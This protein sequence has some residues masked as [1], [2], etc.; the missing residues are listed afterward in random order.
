MDMMNCISITKPCKFGPDRKME[1][2][3]LVEIIQRPVPTLTPGHA[4]IRTLYGGVC[5]SDIGTYL[6]SFLYAKYPQIPGHEFAGEIV[7]IDENNEYGLKKGMIVTI[8]P[9]Y[10][11]GKCYTCRHGFVNCCPDNQTM[12]CSSRDGAFCQYISM[13][14]ERIYDGKGMKARTLALIEPFCIS[15]HAVKRANIQPG[16]KVLVVGAG[17][18]GYLAGAAAKMLGAEVY[19]ADIAP[20]KL[21]AAKQK[22]GLAGTIVNKDPEAFAKAVETFTDGAGFDVCFEA[23]GLPSTVQN[24]IDAV[25]YH[26]RVVII[27]VGKQSMDFFYPVIQKKELCIMGSRNSEKADFLELI[28]YVNAGKFDLESVISAEYNYLDA[29]TAMAEIVKNRGNHLKSI[30]RFD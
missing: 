2:P 21:E 29:P 23:V 5:G 9:Y 16:E 20:D 22:L 25:T 17:T 24:C 19:M 8:N 27:G 28:D 7:D 18:I 3:G 11:C 26:G 6:G 30:F 14:L 4:I 1:E 10:N 12:G 13:P 15:Y